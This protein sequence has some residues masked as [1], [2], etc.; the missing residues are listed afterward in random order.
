MLG[1]LQRGAARHTI[2][3]SQRP[4]VP[5]R[6]ELM[7]GGETAIAAAGGGPRCDQLS[8]VRG[9]GRGGF[10]AGRPRAASAEATPADVAGAARHPRHPAAGLAS[11]FPQQINVA[12]AVHRRIAD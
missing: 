10:G 7:D 1:E 9:L 4:L 6:A 2:G 5:R 8:F 11:R 12:A 3:I